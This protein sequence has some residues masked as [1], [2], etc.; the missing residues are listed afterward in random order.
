MMDNI[1]KAITF[2]SEDAERFRSMQDA[3]DAAR[4]WLAGFIASNPGRSRRSR[5]AIG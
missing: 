4:I 1:V 2:V 3:Y 5:A